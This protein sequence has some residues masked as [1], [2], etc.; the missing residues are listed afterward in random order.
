MKER[1]EGGRKEGKK[2]GG[3]CK[4]DRY[5]FNCLNIFCQ[6]IQIPWT[7]ESQIYLVPMW[8]CIVFANLRNLFC[9]TIVFLLQAN[10]S[11]HTSN[12]Y[13]LLVAATSKELPQSLCCPAGGARR[14]LWHRHTVNVCSQL[15]SQEGHR[16]RPIRNNLPG[17][18]HC[19][20]SWEC[21]MTPQVTRNLWS[22]DF[23]LLKFAFLVDL[24]EFYRRD[25]HFNTSSSSL[26]TRLAQLN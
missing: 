8:F 18:G 5:I 14:G 26:A 12:I 19:Q 20:V 25:D 3:K 10:V 16:C 4:K 6:C 1:K 2:K 9:L 24:K 15:R 11:I 17:H 23:W 7:S 22:C 13:C 21:E